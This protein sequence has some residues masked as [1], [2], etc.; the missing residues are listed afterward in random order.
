MQLDR[1]TQLRMESE[2]EHST[3]ILDYSSSFAD[4]QADFYQY[5]RTKTSLS[6]K[7]CGDYVSRLK[8]LASKYPLDRNFNAS[9]IKDIMNNTK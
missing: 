8:F 2:N 6:K 3:N 5:L 7:A 4:L 1:Y 9:K